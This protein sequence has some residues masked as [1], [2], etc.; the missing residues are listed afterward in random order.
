MN[1]EIKF[2]AWSEE[3]KRINY[4]DTI[5]GSAVANPT[6]VLHN[7]LYKPFGNEFILMQYTNL[8]DKNG[9]EIYEGD[10]IRREFHFSMMQTHC[11]DC[12]NKI[13]DDKFEN[14][15]VV[16]DG[17]KF[18]TKQDLKYLEYTVTGFFDDWNKSEIIGNVYE[19]PELLVK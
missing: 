4:E 16:F 10:I 18:T 15:E 9:K 12:K 3:A 5:E 14:H 8:K 2:R 7:K 6:W 11:S 13:L 1:R 19:N 17:G